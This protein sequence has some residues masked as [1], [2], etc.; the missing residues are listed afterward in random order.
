MLKEAAKRIPKF[1]GKELDKPH[2]LTIAP[3]GVAAYII[4]SKEAYVLEGII[5]LIIVNN[6][7]IYGEMKKVL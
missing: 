5:N 2:S 7:S 4:A 3:T 6:N 1:S